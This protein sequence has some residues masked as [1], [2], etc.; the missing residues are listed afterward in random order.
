MTKNTIQEV[1][2]R[3]QALQQQ[4]EPLSLRIEGLT[5]P[6]VI[7]PSVFEPSRDVARALHGAFADLQRTVALDSTQ[8]LMSRLETLRLAGAALHKQ[9]RLPEPIEFPRL[10]ESIKMDA[11]TELVARQRNMEASFAETVKAMSSPWLNMQDEIG[12]LTG[13]ARLCE[14]GQIL[15]TK[16]T[17]EIAPAR[18]IRSLL[19]DWRK[20]IDWPA[21]IFT[22]P[23]ARSDFYLERGLEPALTDYP[24][25]AFH[26]LLTATDIKG[27]PPQLIGPYSRTRGRDENE[28][29]EG[30]ERNNA[31][32]DLLQR[33][34]VQARRFIA[35]QLKAAY[36]EN[37]LEVGV[38]DDIRKQWEDKRNKARKNGERPE[39]LI[40]YADFSDYERIIVNKTN[41]KGVFAWFF[42]RKTSVE[43]SLRR[44]YV[45]RNSTMHA[46][47]ITQGDELYL[48]A[49]TQ[50]LSVAMDQSEGPR[51]EGMQDD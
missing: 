27:G 38:P 51:S 50:R 28:E 46:R 45:V 33:F 2:R 42:R 25:E 17:F 12:S 44:L 47:F 43:E 31:A 41:W 11:A 29:E 22:D 1:L 16:A 7:D 10:I 48:L 34:E 26:E 15:Q 37:W 21:E 40:A 9:F 14:L 4:L 8:A 24:A 3:Q 32:H 23:F 30:F 5:P 13:I 20:R 49:E 36:G 18:R 35:A 6:R 39:P 19:G